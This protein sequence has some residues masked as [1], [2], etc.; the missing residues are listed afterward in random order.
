MSGSILYA[1]DLVVKMA[2]MILVYMAFTLNWKE[3]DIKKQIN[4]KDNFK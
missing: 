4:V 1:M 2:V 3:R